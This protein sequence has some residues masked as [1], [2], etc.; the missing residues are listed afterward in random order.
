MDRW[1]GSCLKWLGVWGEMK[2][3]GEK[4]I[5]VEREEENVLVK[6]E[7]LEL[8]IVEIVGEEE[9]GLWGYEWV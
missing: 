5:E 7:G 4:V 8:K 2:M 1:I 3:V 6:K 9:E